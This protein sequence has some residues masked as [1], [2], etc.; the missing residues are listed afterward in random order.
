MQS[1]NGTKIIKYL[2]FKKIMESNGWCEELFDVEVG[3]RG[4]SYNSILCCFKKLGFNN[5]LIRSTIKKLSKSSME[6]FF[7]I[8]LV[9]NNKEWTPSAADCKFNDSS[10]ETWN[11]PFSMSPLYQTTKP[12]PN[13]KSIRPVCFINRANTCYSSSIFHI[14]LQVLCLLTGTKSLQNLTLYHQCYVPLVSTWL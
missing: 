7:C 13:A 3:D 4:Y 1:W 11:S 14:H 5:N 6:C 10:K 12:V 2:S 8:F 9:R